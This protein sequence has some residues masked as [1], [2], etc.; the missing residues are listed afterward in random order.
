M[1]SPYLIGQVDPFDPVVNGARVPDEVTFPSSTASLRLRGN[2]STDANG[3]VARSFYPYPQAAMYT[4]SAISAGGTITWTSGTFTQVSRF[5]PFDLNFYQWRPVAYGLRL[6]TPQALTAASGIV[7]IAVMPIDWSGPF[8]A[9][10]QWPLNSADFVDCIW[11]AEVPLSELASKPFTIPGRFTDPG[12][13]RY[14]QVSS[15]IPNSTTSQVEQTP[16]FC[17]IHILLEGAVAS[18]SALYFELQIHVEAI[19]RPVSTGADA[20]PSPYSP[21]ELEA[22]RNIDIGAPVAYDADKTGPSLVMTAL[23]TAANFMRSGTAVQAARM[24]ISLANAYVNGPSF[25]P[26]AFARPMAAITE[27]GEEKYEL[28]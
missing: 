12:A 9:G 26:T 4:P 23:R 6:A 24:G 15:N 21:K 20:Q 7:Y 8:G 27:R 14:R 16:G 18:T 28:V 17:Q 11:H 19:P 10:G 25:R 3:R 5:S 22:A 1:C 13:R 2:L